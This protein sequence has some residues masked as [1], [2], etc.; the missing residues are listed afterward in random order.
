[1]IG[2]K[3]TLHG[4]LAVSQE[5]V[6]AQMFGS[7]LG[8]EEMRYGDEIWSTTV[9]YPE[10]RHF[11]EQTQ[12]WETCMKFRNLFHQWLSTEDFIQYLMDHPSF[13][14]LTLPA[15]AWAG[16]ISSGRMVPPAICAGSPSV[17]DGGTFIAVQ[18]NNKFHHHKHPIESGC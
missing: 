6:T 12:E 18:H 8:G 15:L 1:M 14:S 7:F 13:S 10:A 11:R 4:W 5:S 3:T 2:R 16:P 9:D 17:H